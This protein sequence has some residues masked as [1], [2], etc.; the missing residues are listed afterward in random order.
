MSHLVFVYWFLLFTLYWSIG[1][2]ASRYVR[3]ISTPVPFKALISRVLFNQIYIEL[4][5]LWWILDFSV[6]F[7]LSRLV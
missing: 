6:P 5:L 7:S 1:T 2:V 3:D 4:P